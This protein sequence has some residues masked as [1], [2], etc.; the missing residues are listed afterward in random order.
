[1]N[2]VGQIAA[3]PMPVAIRRL[4]VIMAVGPK[5]QRQGQVFMDT[6]I[7]KPPMRL[8]HTQPSSHKFTAA[9][10]RSGFSWHW[11]GGGGHYMVIKGY[12]TVNGVQYVDVNDP[13]PYTNLNTPNGGTETIMT[14]DNYVSSPGNH[15]HWR[16]DYI[17]VKQ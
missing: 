10:N 14:Y 7:P 15:T 6:Q 13:E 17:F 1:M 5:S 4:P 3:E 11:P 12:L 16:D 2:L 9:S 8:C